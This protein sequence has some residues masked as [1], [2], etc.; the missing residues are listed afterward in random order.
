MTHS[1]AQLGQLRRARR[2]KRL[3]AETS[4]SHPA[5]A[6]RN[7]D[8]RPCSARAHAQ[9][10]PDVCKPLV[11]NGN[12]YGPCEAALALL[13]LGARRWFWGDARLLGLRGG[14]QGLTRHCAGIRA[15]NL[16]SC[17]LKVVAKQLRTL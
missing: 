10:G 9:R 3:Q 5:A 12:D 17:M 15:G 16:P 2:S 14:E 4:W 8:S 11:L 6:D 7:D 13:T 1:V